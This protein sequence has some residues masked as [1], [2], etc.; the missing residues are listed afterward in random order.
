MGE[1][2]PA[3]GADGASN[4]FQA[5]DYKFRALQK[6]ASDLFD[7]TET[8]AQS[9]RDNSKAAMDVAELCAQAE[10]DPR[11]VVN[12]AEVGVRFG[13]VVGGCTQLQ[14]AADRVH[15]AARNLQHEHQ[16]EYGGV[17]DAVTTSPAREARPA[18]YRS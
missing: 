10:V 6:A 12:V 15:Q 1:M 4:G 7:V 3:V 5:V 8:V 16:A 18:F 17:Y 11:H 13:E 14:G 9:M 2:A